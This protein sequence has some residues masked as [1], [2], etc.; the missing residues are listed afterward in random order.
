M[1]TNRLWTTGAL[2]GTWALACGS[3][4]ADLFGYWPIVT[5]AGNVVENL[6]ADGATGRIYNVMNG[7]GPAG[8]AWIDDPERGIVLSFDG[9]A[10]SAY[11]LAGEVPRMTLENDFTWSFW[12]NQDPR[13][14]TLNDIILGNRRAANRGDF[15]PRQFIKFTPTNFEVHMNGNGLD[16]LNYEPVPSARWVHHA[17]VKEGSDLTY[18]R[19]GRSAAGGRLTQ[20]LDVPLPLFFGGDNTEMDA[21]NW[22]GMIDEVSVWDEAL[23]P[24]VIAALAAGVPIVQPP[25]GPADFNLDGAVNLADFAILSDNFNAKYPLSESLFRGDFD[26]NTRV[27]LADFVG[28]REAF[29][30]ASTVPEPTTSYCLLAGLAGWL[31]VRRRR[32][33]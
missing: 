15:D 1:N 18:Y 31:A 17:V 32:I 30:S 10:Q 7:L 29:R 11:V 26:L 22:R 12:A 16:N 33:R 5:G 2:I 14:T 23:L 25:G 9:S 24:G 19:D 27:N 28:F 4:R 21:E 20:A 13:Q 8:S 3:A 6:L